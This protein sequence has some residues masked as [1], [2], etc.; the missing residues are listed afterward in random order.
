[1]ITRAGG[2][3][4]GAPTRTEFGASYLINE[5][6]AISISSSHFSP[7]TISFN[8]HLQMYFTLNHLDYLKAKTYAI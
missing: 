7:L 4:F 8:A 3:T 5:I 1:M 2:L 6:I